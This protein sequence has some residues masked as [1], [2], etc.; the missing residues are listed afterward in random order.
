VE[1]HINP[2]ERII[3]A[4]PLKELLK[5]GANAMILAVLFASSPILAS[6]LILSRGLP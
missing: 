1:E 4:D 2:T 6:L 3:L 5:A